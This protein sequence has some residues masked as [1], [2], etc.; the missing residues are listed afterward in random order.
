MQRRARAKASNSRAN[1]IYAFQGSLE[2]TMGLHYGSRRTKGAK[3]SD[4][5]GV[6]LFRSPRCVRGNL[7]VAQTVDKLNQRLE[8]RATMRMRNLH[9]LGAT[10]LTLLLPPTLAFSTPNRLADDTTDQAVT[11]N[12][13]AVA[14]VVSHHFDEALSLF[15]RAIAL[16]PELR[17]THY[18][19]GCLYLHQGRLGDAIAAFKEELRLNPEFADAYHRMGVAYNKTG[20]HAE[21]I[22]YFTRSLEIDPRQAESLTEIGFAYS[23]LGRDEEALESCK[24]AISLNP[25][26]SLAYN[27]LG[28]EQL[29][30]GQRDEAI[31][32]FKHAQRLEPN[33]PEFYSN[34]A[35]VYADAGR[36]LRRSLNINRQYSVSLITRWLSTI[37]R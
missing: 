25:N 32:A 8:V 29:R 11:L 35:Y 13:E 24:K 15:K 1:A 5:S 28:A 10:L 34:L 33:C 27:N 4:S 23:A 37:W 17:T 18:N 26:S 30:L 19:L 36:L 21:A 14:L 22:E 12:N 16:S 6:A 2:I 9:W 3:E 20:K 31:A 7:F